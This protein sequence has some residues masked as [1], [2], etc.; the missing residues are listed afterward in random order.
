MFSSNDRFSFTATPP[1][2]FYLFLFCA[3]TLFNPYI[4]DTKSIPL[5]LEWCGSGDYDKN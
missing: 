1:N 3:A 2:L 5:V 4:Y